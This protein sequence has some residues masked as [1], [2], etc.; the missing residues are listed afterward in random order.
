MHNPFECGAHI[1]GNGK[2]SVEQ[3]GKWECRMWLPFLPPSSYSISTYKHIVHFF[4]K[5]MLDPEIRHWFCLGSGFGSRIGFGYGST[6]VPVWI[7]PVCIS[8]CLSVAKV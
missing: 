3:H 1:L 8:N 5:L 6:M 4:F 7:Q 2:Q